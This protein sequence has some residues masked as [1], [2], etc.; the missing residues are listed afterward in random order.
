[1]KIAF[2]GTHGTGKTTSAFEMC[3]KMK[4]EYPNK[5]VEILHENASKAPNG[6]FNDKGTE[7]AQLWIFAN[8][9]QSE[10]SLTHSFDIVICDR[11]IFDPIAYTIYKGF[12]DL[13]NKM[14]DMALIHLQSYDQIIFK[15]IQ[16]N[17][18]LADCVHRD[19]NN[20][21]YRQRIEEFLLR[22]YEKVGLKT[23]NRFKII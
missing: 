14:I 1:M 8:Q 20:L 5:R 2:T 3:H 6:L 15:T 18:Y 13:S 12:I 17:N 4:L 10:I 23:D 19:T 21:E 11:T 9:M 22:L 16:N 7:E